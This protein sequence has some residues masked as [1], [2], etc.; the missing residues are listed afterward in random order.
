MNVNDKLPDQ[1]ANLCERFLKLCSFWQW[2][3]FDITTVS[4]LSLTFIS[5]L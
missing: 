2:G 1:F 4:F 3:Q 5:S